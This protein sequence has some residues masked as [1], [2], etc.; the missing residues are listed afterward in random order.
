MIGPPGAELKP[1]RPLA[2]SR[3][4]TH[5]AYF[6]D[7]EGPGPATIRGEEA[8]HA[9]R[10]K[11]VSPGDLV[12]LRNARG[13][14]GEGTIVRILKERSGEWA[15]EIEV[16]SVR[17]EPP[18]HPALHVFA[19]A[20]KGDRLEAMIDGLSQAGAAS[21]R[22]LECA[23]SVVEPRPAKLGRLAR[24]ALESLKQ[25]GRAHA[26]QMGP[27]AGLA[28]ALAGPGT[29][30]LADASGTHYLPSGS[31]DI[32]L[33]VGPEGGFEPREVEGARRAGATVA[34]FGVHTMRT[35]T[36]AIIAA[37]IVIDSE[38]RAR[39]SR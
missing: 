23:R 5:I 24:V 2:E 31:A 39:V 14:V 3:L 18:V 1:P 30:V 26:L 13:R 22:P 20:P 11:R 16:S 10:V 33:L 34:S 27:E 36:A 38:R 37:A 32:T 9:A 15:I 8:R 25:C 4:S 17:D 19:A 12:S 7:L 21:W 28:D 35:E 6:P 29:R